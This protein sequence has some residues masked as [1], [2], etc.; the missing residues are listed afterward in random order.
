MLKAIEE[1]FSNNVADQKFSN[2]ANNLQK[3]FQM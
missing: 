3:M 2:F 1:R